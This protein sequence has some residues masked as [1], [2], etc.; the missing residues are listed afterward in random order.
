LGFFCVFCRKFNEVEPQ[1]KQYDRPKNCLSR[2]RV[3]EQFHTVD[4]AGT[5]LTSVTPNQRP[6]LST[7][8]T[9]SCREGATGNQLA[10]GTEVTA[11][12]PIPPAPPVAAHCPAPPAIGIEDL[13]GKFLAKPKMLKVFRASPGASQSQ[14]VFRFAEVISFRFYFKNKY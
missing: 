14:T 5:T 12:Q 13:P 6:I 3:C 1:S 10:A 2:E 7:A 4:A 11:A 8:R 9:E